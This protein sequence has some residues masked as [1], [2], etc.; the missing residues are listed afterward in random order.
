MFRVPVSCHFAS[1][2]FHVENK[3]LQQN[4][5]FSYIPTPTLQLLKGSWYLKILG[6]KF[7]EKIIDIFSPTNFM[8][9]TNL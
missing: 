6:D 4:N 5:A 2:A 8:I 7:D 9:N 3:Q 1:S